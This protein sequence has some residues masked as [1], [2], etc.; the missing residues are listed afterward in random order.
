MVMFK[1]DYG[2]ID[3]VKEIIRREYRRHRIEV[4]E[5]NVAPEAQV[6]QP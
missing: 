5:A 2:K 6:L 3:D 4:V 1:P